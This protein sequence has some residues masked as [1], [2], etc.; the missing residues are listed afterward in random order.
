MKDNIVGFTFLLLA[1]TMV[2]GWWM[3]IIWILNQENIIASGEMIISII[4]IFVAPLG[5]IM[6][7]LV[8]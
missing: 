8:H 4:G 2:Y 1:M 6:G 3:N 7:L 5:A